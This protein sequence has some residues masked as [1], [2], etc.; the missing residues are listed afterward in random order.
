MTSPNIQGHVAPGFEGVRDAFESNFRDRKEIGAACSVVIEDEIVVD[1]WGGMADHKERRPWQADTLVTMFSTTKGLS[2]L[3]VAHAHSRGLFDY[4]EKVA[5]YWPEFAANGKQDITVRTLLSHQAGLSAIDE[6]MTI[7]TLAD[8]DARGAAIAQQ[9]PAWTPGQKHGYHAVTLGYYESELIRR[10]DPQHRT[11]GR[12]FAEEL[13]A[14]LGLDFHIGLPDEIPS[15]RVARLMADWLQL[16]MLFALGSMPR[17]F[18][19]K[20][21]NPRSLTARSFANPRMMPARYNTREV[22]RLEMPASNGTG[23]ARS[24]ATAY[25]VFANG[26]TRL[27]ID[28]ATLDSLIAPATS[29]TDGRLD[30]VLRIETKFSLGVS[31]PQPGFDFGSPQAFG[32]AGAGGSLGYADPEL[33]MGFCYAMNRMGLDLLDDPRAIVLRDAAREAAGKHLAR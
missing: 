19:R 18:V 6:K 1:L 3:A 15:D 9:A 7:E 20:F 4:D 27:Q 14:P 32:T 16:R 29:P 28:P 13:A 24:V 11:I 22:L 10:V 31:K 8:H 17:P 5:T 25:G 23:T 12:Y 21:F 2:A 26:G 30:E 33:K